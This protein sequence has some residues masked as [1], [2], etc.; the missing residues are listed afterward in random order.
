MAVRSEYPEKGVRNEGSQYLTLAEWEAQ[1]LADDAT[2]QDVIKRLNELEFEIGL[3]T[4]DLNVE[5]LEEFERILADLETVNDRVRLM[6]V[7]LAIALTRGFGQER[8]TQA[9]HG[10]SEWDAVS[11]NTSTEE[12]ELALDAPGEDEAIGV[13]IDVTTNKFTVVYEGRHRKSG[14]GKAVGSWYV[15][16]TTPG[17]LTQTKPGFP[18]KGRAILHIRDDHWFSVIPTF[19]ALSQF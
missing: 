13:L 12:Y 10:F 19:G 5:L 7:Q 1:Q 2:L 11:F 4:D 16:D 6:E 17:L 15:S 18:A 9:A 14:H 3:L 8:V